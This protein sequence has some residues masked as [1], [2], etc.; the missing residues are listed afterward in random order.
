MNIDKISFTSQKDDFLSSAIHGISSEEKKMASEIIDFYL[1]SGSDISLAFSFVCGALV[2]RVFDGKMF[3]FLFPYPI[4]ENADVGLALEK[5]VRYCILEEIEPIFENVPSEELPVF[6]NL[7]F[8]HINCDSDSADSETYRI[9]L[10][11]ECA[12]IDEYP[13]ALF[14]NVELTSLREEDARDYA[15]L[16]RDE[17]N[18]KY[19]GYDYRDD[20]ESADDGLFIELAGHDFNSGTAISLAIRVDGMFVGEVLIS[21]FDYKGGADVAIRILPEYQRRGYASTARSLVFDVAARIG[22]VALYARVYRENTASVSLFSK[23]AD[24]KNEENGIYVFA[25]KLYQ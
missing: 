7:G 16:W 18:N 15:R 11:S 4:T 3:S 6:F 5:I 17:V 10:K 25:Y 19:W 1:S 2:I 21:S 9:T 24:E 12:L 22:L 8:R 23:D 14:E 20:Y 13:N